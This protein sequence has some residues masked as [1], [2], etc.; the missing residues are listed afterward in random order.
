QQE[1]DPSPAQRGLVVS[2][3]IPGTSFQVAPG[4]DVGGTTQNMP[5]CRSKEQFGCVITY[6]SF[7]VDAPPHAGSLFGRPGNGTESACTNPAALDG[8]PAVLSSALPAAGNW[9]L[10]DGSA[11]VTTPLVDVPG[12][13]TGECVEKDGYHYLAITTNGDPND[14]RA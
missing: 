10:T 14:P 1:I 9:V 13:L 5:L 12:L 7:P 11:N 3:I 6:Q 2:A 4:R 8:G